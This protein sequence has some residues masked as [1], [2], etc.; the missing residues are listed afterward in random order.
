MCY[1]FVQ[2][3]QIYAAERYNTPAEDLK[4]A[5]DFWEN[6]KNESLSLNVKYLVD[7]GLQQKFKTKD[8]LL[9]FIFAIN[10]QV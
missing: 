3:F 10:G 9:K 1:I 5:I 8:E 7:Y 2:L 4:E 6:H